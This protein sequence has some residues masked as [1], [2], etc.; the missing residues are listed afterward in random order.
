[1]GF[2]IFALFLFL[3]AVAGVL[4]FV[5]KVA[6]GLMLGLIFASAFG[7]WYVKRR[8]RRA[9]YGSPRKARWP[10]RQISGSRVEVLD[11]R[12]DR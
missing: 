1:M 3:L 8:V 5:V 4:G 6:L 2:L 9:L 12:D 11:R 7:V 10:G